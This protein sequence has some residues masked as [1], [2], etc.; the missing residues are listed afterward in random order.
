MGKAWAS[1]TWCGL[2]LESACASIDLEP[3]ISAVLFRLFSV[4]IAIKRRVTHSR[5]R[6]R[7]YSDS[8]PIPRLWA[9]DGVTPMGP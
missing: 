2:M 1:F 6:K 9:W 7:D 8:C 4:F 5:G 3:E